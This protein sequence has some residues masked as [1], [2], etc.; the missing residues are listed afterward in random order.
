MLLHYPPWIILTPVNPPSFLMAG[1][2][3]DCTRETYVAVK[4]SGN[5]YGREAKSRHQAGDL[6]SYL[7]WIDEPTICLC[8]SPWLYPL[9]RSASLPGQILALHKWSRSRILH[10]ANSHRI[11]KLSRDNSLC[12]RLGFPALLSPL[13]QVIGLWAACLYQVKHYRVCHEERPWSHRW[14]PETL[15]LVTCVRR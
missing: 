15:P 3:C 10:Q 1:I 6:S 11:L 13:K 2:R 5:A 14:A 9:E 12:L 8:K 4:V 7:L